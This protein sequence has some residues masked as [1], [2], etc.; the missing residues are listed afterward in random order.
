MFPL[1]RNPTIAE[2][3][4]TSSLTFSPFSSRLSRGEGFTEKLWRKERKQ[5]FTFKLKGENTENPE[6]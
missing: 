5:L 4:V 3:L 2:E 1:N 6:V